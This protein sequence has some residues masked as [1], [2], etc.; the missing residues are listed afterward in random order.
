MYRMLTKLN[1]KNSPDPFNP[2]P[3]SDQIFIKIEHEI[4]YQIK[5]SIWS[6]IRHKMSFNSFWA[7]ILNS[8]DESIKKCL[9]N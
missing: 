7:D 4:Q 1:S 3:T 5:Y 9:I 6:N 2:K 8:V